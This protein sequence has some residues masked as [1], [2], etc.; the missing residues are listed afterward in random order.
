MSSYPFDIQECSGVIEPQL[1]S[2]SS[3]QLVP[4]NLSYN[5]PQ[6]LLKYVLIDVFYESPDLLVKVQD[7]HFENIIKWYFI[8]GQIKHHI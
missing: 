1:G 7:F 4:R 8:L 6:D 5:G 2:E 3:V